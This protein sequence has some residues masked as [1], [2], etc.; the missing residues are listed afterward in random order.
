V[1]HDA[2]RVKV[3]TAMP[4]ETAMARLAPR[5]SPRVDPVPHTGRAAGPRLTPHMPIRREPVAT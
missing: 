1:V 2:R 3:G 5:R 4:M